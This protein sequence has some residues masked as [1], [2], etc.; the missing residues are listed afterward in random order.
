MRIID[1]WTAFLLMLFFLVG[2][3]GMFA[4][5]ATS[6][7]LQRATA[8]EVLLDETLDAAGAPDGAA[9]LERLR[10][11]LGSLAPSVLEGTSPI[12]QRVAEA[13]RVIADE[14]RRESAS[15]GYRTRLMLGV[16]T[17][18]AGAFGAGMMS[19]VRRQATRQALDVKV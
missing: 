10:E 11:P 8:R 18:L 19:I 17:V 12:A 2:L 6:I 5:Y 15:I 1:P 9:R 3:C 4:S 13:R 16:I 7:P 14:Q